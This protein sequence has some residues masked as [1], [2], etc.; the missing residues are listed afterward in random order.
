MIDMQPPTQGAT[1]QD[2]E[3]HQSGALPEAP[4]EAGSVTKLRALESAVARRE[5]SAAAQTSRI[6]LVDDDPSLL[7]S[8]GRL[9]RSAGYDVSTAT[10]GR[11]AVDQVDA[12]K[13]D[14]IISDIAMPNMDGIQ[15]LRQVR[16]HD[17]L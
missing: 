9:L 4:R 3:E 12:D 2:A 11:D 5:H 15:L 7:R 16:E 14:V 17:L 6:L 10:N 13:F 8:Y 1:V